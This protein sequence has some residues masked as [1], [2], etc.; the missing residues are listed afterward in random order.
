MRY[1]ETQLYAGQPAKGLALI[2]KATAS[3]GLSLPAQ[4]IAARLEIVARWLLAGRPGAVLE[5]LAELERRARR[6]GFSHQVR[7]IR[8]LRSRILS[9]A[10]SLK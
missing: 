10:R 3:G 5:A 1:G 4:I 2:E 6:H 9:G 8:R 7:T